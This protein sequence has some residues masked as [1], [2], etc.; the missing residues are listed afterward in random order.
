MTYR[1]FF[2]QFNQS[3]PSLQSEA[4]KLSENM[5]QARELYQETAHKAMKRRQE[6]EKSSDFRL[7]A[8]NLMR[9]ISSTKSQSR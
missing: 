7:W 9:N 6:I 4:I 1:E 5:E 2:K 3:A 8:G